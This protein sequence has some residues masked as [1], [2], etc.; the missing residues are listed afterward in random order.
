MK[1]CVSG[2]YRVILL[3]WTT[4]LEQ[5]CT[6]TYIQTAAYFRMIS[7]PVK[8]DGSS[9]CSYAR[10]HT[11][12]KCLLGSSC[13]PTCTGF[14]WKFILE[15]FI[16][17][18]PEK[19]NLLQ[20]DK[21]EYLSTVYC[22]QWRTWPSSYTESFVIIRTQVHD[23]NNAFQTYLRYFGIY[24]GNAIFLRLL[25]MEAQEQEILFPSRYIHDLSQI[26]KIM[27]LSSQNFARHAWCSLFRKTDGM[28]FVPNP[29]NI[30]KFLL[31]LLLEKRQ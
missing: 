25:E 9:N 10:L 20:S 12:E 30:W 8:S 4:V 26:I 29:S 7:W 6:Y 13:L 11:C 22:C 14:S 15:T 19:R 31:L 17:I 23:L 24:F 18:C 28:L 16:K 5:S 3:F 21:N 1:H 27:L 2:G